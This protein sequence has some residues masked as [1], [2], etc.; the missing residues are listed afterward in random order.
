MEREITGTMVEYFFVC[1]RK[2]YYFTKN[3]TMEQENEAVL[4]G[5]LIDENSYGR[6]EK[7]ISVDGVISIDYIEHSRILHEIKK[8]RAIEESAKWQLKYYLWYL[9]Q[10]GITG[11]RGRID[12]PLLKQNINIE[13]SEEDRKILRKVVREIPLICDGKIPSRDPSLSICKKCAYYD[14]CF[15]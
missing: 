9:E 15:I 4:L 2:L 8:S 12:Y 10:K 3:L 7:H 11:L 14:L 13:L 1:K 6:E 5:K